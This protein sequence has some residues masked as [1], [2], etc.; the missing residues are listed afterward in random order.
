MDREARLQG[1]LLLSKK[2]HLS[3]SPVKEPPPSRSLNGIPC[4]EM[5]H[6]YSPPSII[7]QSPRY[8]SPPHTS[9]PLAG[10]RPPWREMLTSG[11][12]L[13]I[14]SRVPS[15][16]SYPPPQAPTT[17]PLQKET[18]HS[19]SPLHHLSK[20]PVDEPSSRVPKR[21]PYEKRCLSPEPF[22]HILQGPQQGS[23]T[24]RFPSQSSHRQR[25]YLQ[26]PFQPY[27]KDPGR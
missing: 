14:S 2:S 3:G 12:F 27:H 26:G 7:H 9:C 21:G 6:H 17:P 19:Q 20:Y 22:L 13:N 15:E 5:P 23:P 18:L 16:G 25:H 4:R 8:T 24:S 11:D 10:K 1:I